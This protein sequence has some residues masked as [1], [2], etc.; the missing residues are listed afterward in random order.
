MNGEYPEFGLALGVTF[1]DASLWTGGDVR[2]Q[3]A[4][5]V[6]DE[7]DD[8]GWRIEWADFGPD[9]IDSE[10]PVSAFGRVEV[11]L[12]R[13]SRSQPGKDGPRRDSLESLV[14]VIS[15]ALTHRD[16]ISR[17]ESIE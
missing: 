6:D 5:N 9:M 12:G 7:L 11:L 8:T 17:L 14:T 16:A 4:S 15:S 1:K 3:L 2:I 13:A 10:I